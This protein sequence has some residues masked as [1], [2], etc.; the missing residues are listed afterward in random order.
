MKSIL[1]LLASLGIS[2]NA[3]SAKV[4]AQVQQVDTVIASVSLLDNGSLQIDKRDGQTVVAPLSKA[5]ASKLTYDAQVLSGVQL[6]TDH[7]QVV[8]DIMISPY[9]SN[10]LAIA[11]SSGNLVETISDN[12]CAVADYTHPKNP[13]L[14]DL[15]NTLK[16]EMG[17]L[18]NQI[19]DN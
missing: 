8:C 2:A 19:L 5:N 18:A 7:R 9:F 11:D 16:N 15:G 1:V 14:T 13:N 6:T 17:V 10:T 4:V 12:S 3:V